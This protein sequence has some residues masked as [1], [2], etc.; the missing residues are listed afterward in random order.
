MVFAFAFVAVAF[1][2]NADAV[3]VL[4]EGEEVSVVLPIEVG[5]WLGGWGRGWQ[6]QK[7]T[8]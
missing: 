1:A 8:P 4:N 6:K 3:T 5:E 7:P 2:A